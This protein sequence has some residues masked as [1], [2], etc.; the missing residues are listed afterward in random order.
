[1]TKL[2][3]ALLALAGVTQMVLAEDERD[4]VV[5]GKVYEAAKQKPIEFANI[6]LFNNKDSA[7]VTGTTSK[8]DGGFQIDKIP[9]GSYYVDV[10]FIGFKTRRFERIEIASA[11]PEI[12][13]GKILLQQTAVNMKAVEVQGEASSM[14]YQIDKKVINVAQQHTALSG[15]AV[16]V[17]ENVPS[18]TVDIE[19]NVSFR[20]S[21]NF[22]VLVDGRPSVLEPSEALQQIPAS[23]IVNIE[24]ITNPSAKYDPQGAAGIINIVMKREQRTGQS[25]IANLNAG[26]GDKYGGDFLFELRDGKYAA[27]FG[28]DYNHRVFEG[29]ENETNQTRRAGISSFFES[30]G[31]SRRNNTSLGARG[32]LK[33]DLSKKDFLQLGARLGKRDNR[34]TANLN[35]EEW[36]DTA[37]EKLFFLSNSDRE[38][39]RDFY[40]LTSSYR[41]NFAK[42]G[43]ELN[44]ELSFS[45]RTGDEATINA[46]L[47][48]A[49]ARLSGRRTTETGP[50]R[51]FEA[52]LDYTLPLGEEA[53]FEAGYENEIEYSEDRTGLAEYDTVASDYV[54][55]PQYNYRTRYDDNTHALYALYAGKWKRLGYQAGLR[56]EYT[57]RSINFEGAA[58]PFKLGRWDYFPTL[59]V[60]RQFSA[61]QQAMASYTRRIDRPGG[62]ELEPF[63]TWR[64]AYNVQ[65]SNPSLQ[66][67]YIDSYELGYQTNIGA[68]VIST[69]AYYRVTHNRIEDVRS[70]YADNVTLHSAAN[71]G[72]DY[73]FGSELAWNFSLAEKWNVSM[74]GNLYNYRIA[75]VLLN[76]SFERESFNWNARMSHNVKLGGST[77][78]QFDGNYNSPT[79]S[80]Q[81]RREG[82]FTAHA[83][84]K[85]EI[86]GKLLTATLQVRD[87]FRSAKNEYLA[88]GA[89]FYTYNRSKPEAPMVMLN[90]K[91]NFNNYKSERN[92][93]REEQGEEE[94][95]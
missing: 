10:Q 8:E 12:D 56:S 25:G 19:G 91:Y 75:G 18:V 73:A 16:D 9:F 60:S 61:G 34:N 6:I 20:G 70:V 85:Y 4:G 45:R 13:L 87:L 15:T 5:R 47:N 62:G 80:S 22:T 17:L 74:L 36:S 37:L 21:N 58:Q 63:E 92:S 14:T 84:L 69:E 76:E 51:D 57:G 26:A 48:D 43:H 50:S 93:N 46:L 41:R 79:V 89:D 11:K 33:L 67:E 2:W 42:K 29:R 35:Y 71:I 78:L 81:G 65:I 40:A 82:F 68:S 27:T 3:A 66:P 55:L 83:A 38:R 23:T 59:H 94:E 30:A 7:L 44:A 86:L 64:D 95:F 77:Q 31:D 49:G 24:I 39:D 1:M 54:A 72:K 90:L 32:E 53:K 52:K 88:E 28:V